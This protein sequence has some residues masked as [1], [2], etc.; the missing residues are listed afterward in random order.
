MSERTESKV[1][2]ESWTVIFD[3]SHAGAG[4]NIPFKNQT[5]AKGGLVVSEACKVAVL[6]AGSEQEAATAVRRAFGDGCITGKVKCAKTSNVK[7]ASA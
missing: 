3:Q 6:E 2:L 7:E 4:V 1:A 5:E